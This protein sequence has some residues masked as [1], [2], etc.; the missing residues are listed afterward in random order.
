MG[1]DG[2][3]LSARDGL[4]AAVIQEVATPCK[5]C[6]E[7]SSAPG[8]AQFGLRLRAGARFDS[9]YELSFHPAE[10]RVRL[11]DQEITAVEG[12]D[13]GFSLEVV[14]YEDLIDACIAGRRTV[15]N[16][17]PESQGRDVWLYAMNGEVDFTIRR[18][19]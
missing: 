11:Q 5:L 7:V 9:G 6:V 3:H 16:R 10:R 4:A 19:A 8:T 14:L 1:A 17:L 15:A 2:I 12:L 13:G 18:T